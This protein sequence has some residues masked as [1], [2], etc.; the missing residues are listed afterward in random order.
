[1]KRIRIDQQSLRALY[2]PMDAA[3]ERELRQRIRGLPQGKESQYMRRKTG[4]AV[5]L[6]ALLAIALAATALAAFAVSHGFFEEV[7][8]V[9]LESG[10]YDD[11][12]LE[13]KEA[14]VRL[15][16][17]N[18]ILENP[19]PW[20][21]ALALRDA[22]AREAALDALF[23][24]RYGVGGRTDVVGI[25][26]ILEAEKGTF[27]TW[28]MEEKAWYSAL[29]LDLGL[30]GYD[31][32]V[33]LLPGEDAIPAAEAERIARE[34]VIAAY[35]LAPDALEGYT[36]AVDCCEHVSEAGIRPPYFLVLLSGGEEEPSYGVAVSQEGR[37]LDSADGYLGVTSPQE[38]AEAARRAEQAPP[39]GEALAAHTAALPRLK[40]QVVTIDRAMVETAISL[41]DGTALVAGT[42]LD[43][44]TGAAN[45]TF[46][47]CI[48]EAGQVRWRRDWA[49]THDG[50]T[51]IKAVMQL[52][53][54]E[55]LLL[56]ERWINGKQSGDLEICRYDRIRLGADGRELEICEL[57]AI[58]EL[59]GMKSASYE[60]M[61]GQP[62]HGGLLV[63][64]AMTSRNIMT[65][66]A[67]NAQGEAQFVLPFEDLRSYAPYLK[68][69]QEGYLL[70]AWNETA[71]RPI[72]RFYD[73]QGSLVREGADDPALAGLRINRVLSVGDGTLMATSG[74]M[75]AGEWMLAHLGA[76]GALIDKAVC[77]DGTVGFIGM[78]TE[79]VCVSGRYAYAAMH[80]SEVSGGEMAVHL[81]LILSSADGSIREYALEGVET[82]SPWGECQLAALGEGSVLL[83]QNGDA[84]AP[85]PFAAELILAGIPGE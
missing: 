25:F 22:A 24:A 41:A 72:L 60:L 10:Y 6:A 55:I 49:K 14:I 30:A 1:M 47:L 31:S 67:L 71:Q 65:Y 43:H 52:E 48:D 18:G 36:A 85:V 77:A 56:R 78:P 28:S 32:E 61:F 69:T 3:F 20:E 68:T 51:G 46:A 70:T 23:A 83:T 58:S 42:T 38:D 13:D 64:A 29:M 81:G 73:A 35:G 11:W 50:N 8:R 34:A 57:P 19:S 12:S 2:P 66:A 33:F 75:R 17:E 82:V 9:Q 15:M 45:G 40:A 27:D 74:F 5:L 62:G 63:S 84:L 37:V 53:G 80:H 44:E 54:G 39:A 76:D 16:E 59:T 4:L 26:S 21:A 7:A 79:L